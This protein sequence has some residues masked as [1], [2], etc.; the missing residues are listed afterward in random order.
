MAVSPRKTLAVNERFECHSSYSYMKSTGTQERIVPSSS[1]R[2]EIIF[3]QDLAARAHVS[4]ESYPKAF[5]LKSPFMHHHRRRTSGCTWR[6]VTRSTAIPSC[7]TRVHAYML[8]HHDRYR[9][10]FDGDFGN[11]RVACSSRDRLG[12]FITV[13]HGGD[14]ISE[15]DGR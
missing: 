4:S 8:Y 12:V 5:S 7:G 9:C 1:V 13:A 3:T 2:R 14:V 15:P 6:A 10:A 11:P